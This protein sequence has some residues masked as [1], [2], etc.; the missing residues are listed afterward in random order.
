MDVAR[1]GVQAAKDGGGGDNVTVLAFTL[2]A[3]DRTPNK[4]DRTDP[5]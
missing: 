1:H 3:D 5:R 2:Y 4:D